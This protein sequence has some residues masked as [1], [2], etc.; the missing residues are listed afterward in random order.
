MANNNNKQQTSR[1]PVPR[2]SN[3]NNNSRLP[4]SSRFGSSSSG[5]SRFGGSSSRSSSSRF[6]SSS[7]SRFGGREEVAWT[8]SPANKAGVRISLKGLGDPL[9]RLLGTK[10]NRE[11]SDPAKVS[12]LLLKDE[13]LREK[14]EEVLDAAWESYEFRGAALLYPWEENIRKAFTEDIQPTPPPPPKKDK[15]DNDDEYDDEDYY[16]DDD[17]LDWLAANQTNSKKRYQSLRA[18]DVAFVMNILARSRANV[19][20]GNT[21]LA[22]EPGFLEKTIICDDPRIVEIAQ[23]TGCIDEDW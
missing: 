22:L 21:P 9:Q 7:A 12:E 2:N 8:I 16:E 23:A 11:L 20:V 10:L 14:L 17:D 1:F 3:Q 6:G 13:E 15:N 4:G 19:V 5:S 18:I